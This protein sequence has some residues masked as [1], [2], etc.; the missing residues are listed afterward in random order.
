MN[1]VN[2]KQWLFNSKMFSLVNVLSERDI[3]ISII[4]IRCLNIEYEA[5]TRKQLD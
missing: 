5:G 1:H 2:I 3:R 4:H